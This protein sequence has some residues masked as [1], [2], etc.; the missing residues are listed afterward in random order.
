[1]QIRKYREVNPHETYPV[2]KKQL[3]HVLS[4]V[5]EVTAIYGLSR[6]FEFDSRQPGKPDINGVIVA[7]AS[8]HRDK[9]IHFY[10]F[11]IS[12][13]DYPEKANNDFVQFVLPHVKAWMEQQ[14]AKP[15]TAILG[16]EELIIEWNGEKHTFHYSKFL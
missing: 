10:L 14:V 2:T 7:S 4:S 8:C 16:I 9:T 1:M 3:K 11:P 15:E 6:K 13:A 12:K 5:Q